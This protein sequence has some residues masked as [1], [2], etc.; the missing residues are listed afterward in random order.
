MANTS[1]KPIR[2]FGDSGRGIG[3][4]GL[5]ERISGSTEF[6]SCHSSINAIKN[7]GFVKPL[8][9]NNSWQGC[10]DGVR[11]AVMRFAGEI[12]LPELA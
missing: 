6:E 5:D 8:F 1:H 12:V 9:S 7:N 2:A 10:M 11:T 4:V 3:S